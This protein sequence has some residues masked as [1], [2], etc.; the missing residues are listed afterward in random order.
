[1]SAHEAR[2]QKILDD[3]VA[4]GV[5]GVSLALSLPGKDIALYQSGVADKYLGEGETMDVSKLFRVARVFDNTMAVAYAA[6]FN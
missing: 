5:V 6:W 3:H 1:M 2:M 4:R